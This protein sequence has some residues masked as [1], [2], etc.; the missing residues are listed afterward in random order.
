M[1]P[2][3]LFGAG[4]ASRSQIV[5]AQKRL[6]VYWE[7]TSDGDKATAVIYGTPGTLLA[8]TLADIARG[9]LPIG[10]NLYAVNG[11]VVTKL[12]TSL[13][14]T[15]L[16]GGL[17]SATGVVSMCANQS[18]MLITDGAAGKYVTLPA[19]AVTTVGA[20]AYPDTATTCACVGGYFVV[21]QPSTNI[22]SVS[23]LNDVTT[24]PATFIQAAYS[25]PES[26]VAVNADHGLLMLFGR[27]YLEYWTV[28]GALDF[29]FAHIQGADQQ[30]GLAAKW[31]RA[32]IN[33]GVAFL[34]TM[35]QGQYQVMFVD[36]INSFAPTRI[37]NSEVEDVIRRV[38][39]V[40]SATA[41]SYMV[42]G[43]PFYQLTFPADNL[44]LLYDFSTSIWSYAQ[45]GV[46]TSA[47]HVGDLSTTF[48]GVTYLS[49]YA[50]GNVYSSELDTYTDNGTAIKRQLVSKHLATGT[51]LV[52]AALQLE[53][54]TG[55]GL[56]SGQGSDPM[57]TLEVSKDGGRT[58]GNER[59]LKLYPLGTYDRRTI[60]RRAA[61][62][63]DVTFRLTMTDPVKFALARELADI[64]EGTG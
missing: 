31:S 10:D 14:A 18:D 58:Y 43:H 37:S 47:R 48:N 54:E 26:L 23:A 1:K 8:F 61:N 24:W 34:A 41:L 46:A 3:Q 29:P 36:L 28:G 22:F 40:A 6:N 64:E 20:A 53:F 42:D 56:S 25:S 32:H 15:N 39:T 17:A 57:V 27:T 7:I 59:Q 38:T 5:C 62:G 55:V 21:E 44:T 51:H 52:V 30:F 19:G 4:T 63:Y 35:R 2:I 16:G 11:A 33:N 50:N 9:F 12:D 13:A 49:D 45:T 60:A